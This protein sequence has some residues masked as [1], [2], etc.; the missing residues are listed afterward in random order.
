MSHCIWP[1]Q[2]Q[3]RSLQFPFRSTIKE[4]TTPKTDKKRPQ[5]DLRR[6]R[7]DSKETWEILTGINITRAK[8]KVRCCEFRFE[9]QLRCPNRK[10]AITAISN[11]NNQ[12]PGDH[13]NFRKN[14][15]GV[16]RPFSELS[17]EFQGILGAALGPFLECKIPLGMA[18]HD[19]SNTKTTILGATPGAIL[20]I[21]GYPH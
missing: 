19:L 2:K 18:S 5:W 17:G 16:K 8:G 4:H 10:I 12:K 21:V 3:I 15:L 6:T 11:R 1:V 7:K 14:A 9:P 20:R 13:P